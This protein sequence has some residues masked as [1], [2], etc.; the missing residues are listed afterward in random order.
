MSNKTT[1]QELRTRYNAGW[2]P[3]PTEF[4]NENF[5]KPSPA[6][7]WARFNITDGDEFGISIGDDTQVFRTIGILTIQL[8]APLN[9]GSIDILEKA[10]TIAGVFRNWCGTTVTCRAASVRNIGNDG[11]GW[12]QVNIIV[13]FKVD[14]IH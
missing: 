10:D 1:Y 5:V 8:F 3:V 13:P 4:P 7:P 9:S 2:A 6:A 11:F 12:Y 14:K